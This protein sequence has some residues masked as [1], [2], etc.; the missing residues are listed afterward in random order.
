MNEL[1]QIEYYLLML[2]GF[3][4]FVMLGVMYWVIG[5]FNKRIRMFDKI[6]TDSPQF[7]Q[8][9]IDSGGYE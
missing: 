1:I 3:V 5:K 7:M 4:C 2:V 9:L 8:L 6:I